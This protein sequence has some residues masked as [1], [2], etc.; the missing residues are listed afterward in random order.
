MD[1]QIYVSH[2]LINVD[3]EDD[4]DAYDDDDNIFKENILNVMLSAY[5]HL[6]QKT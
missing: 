2:C 1:I 4:D 5:F 6:W 3:D